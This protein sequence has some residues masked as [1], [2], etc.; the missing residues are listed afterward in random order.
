MRNSNSII[1]S[2][3]NTGNI[4]GPV[5]DAGQIVSASFQVICGDV[6]AN[7]TVKIQMSN[8][9]NSYGAFQGSFQPTNW[10]DISGASVSVASG[11]AS[12]PIVISQMCFRWIRAVYT[13][14]SGGSS[15]LAVQINYL[16]V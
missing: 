16:S 11:V 15:T 2:G 14:S 4:V 13:R 1:L 6:T 9:V 7:G 10:T 5:E 3:N 12:N 8:D